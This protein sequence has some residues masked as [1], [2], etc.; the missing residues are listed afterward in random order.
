MKTISI[1]G[2]GYI[3][4]P[5]SIIAA[6]NGY[7]VFGFDVDLSKIEKI[8]SGLSPIIEKNI[9]EKLL[10]V[11]TKKLLVAS[12]KI[13][14]AE[15]FLVAV[16][17]PFLENS[18]KIKKADLSYVFSAAKEI[19]KVINSG[20]LVILE[21]TVPV[22]TTLEFA[23]II[24]IES[25][26]KLSKDFYVSHCPERVLPG[27][28][29][30]ELVS[31]DRIVGGICEKASNLSKQFYSLFVKGQIYI[32]DYKTA[33]MVKLAEN[34]YRDLNI[35]Y[36]NQLAQM[37]KSIGIEPFK[38]IELTNKHP[39]VNIL[40][41]GCGVGG[42]CIAVDPWF[43][44]QTFPNNS[45]ILQTARDINDQKPEIVIKNVLDAVAKINKPDIPRPRVLALGLTFKPDVDDLRGSPALKIAAELNKKREI[46]DFAVLEPNLGDKLLDSFGFKLFYNL[47]ESVEWADLILILV[48]HSI[49]S[50]IKNFNLNNK[51]VI[52][53][54][55]LTY[56][57]YEQNSQPNIIFGVHG[58]RDYN[59]VR[60]NQ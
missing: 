32:T 6:E 2:L 39:R 13:K 45:S 54:C 42:H 50:Q 21:S 16:P 37:A 51:L 11:V 28:I 8:N 31:N 27:K 19:S 53:E 38:L 24:E 40:S 22:G 10:D 44:I 49:F 59:D 18:E 29:F 5:T 36:A 7:K 15:I 9:E 35:A 26:L 48:K 20:N 57:L 52:D 46:F 33:E 3:G 25:G 17:T 30:E 23:K 43:L 58:I 47:S 4:L 1:V 14:P 55:G 56:E 60:G 34:S 41:P 12:N